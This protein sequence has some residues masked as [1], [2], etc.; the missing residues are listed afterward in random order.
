MD[1]NK[2]IIAAFIAAMGLMMTRIPGSEADFCP[3]EETVSKEN[4]VPVITSEPI[5]EENHTET[6][7]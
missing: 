7:E 2:M 5:K 6:P 4:I 3:A 1:M